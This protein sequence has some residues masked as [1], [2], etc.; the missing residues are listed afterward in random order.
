MAL[1]TAVGCVAAVCA[2]LSISVAFGN[3]ILQSA[4]FSMSDPLDN[5]LFSAGIGFAVL[6]FLLGLLGLVAGLTRVNVIILLIVM[7]AVAGRAWN[8]LPRLGKESWLN[9]L[10]GLD[11]YGTKLL[12]ICIGFFLLLEAILS[13]APLSGSD[14]MQYHFTVPLLHLGTPDRPIFWL[15]NSFLTGLGHELIE[16][17]LALGS[18]RISLMLIFLGGCGTAVALFQLARRW[19]PANWALAAMLTFVATPLVFWQITTAGTPDI[20]MAFYILLAVMAAGQTDVRKNDRWLVL[21]SFYSGAAAG[22]KYTGW[23]IPFVVI[24][25]VLWLS[26]SIWWTALCSLAALASGALPQLRN[27]AWTGDPFFPFL[28]RWIGRVATNPYGLQ[29][30]HDTLGT[31]TISRDPLHL[32]WYS[33]AM[34]LQGSNPSLGNYFGPV[35]LSFIPLLLFC[36]WRTRGVWISGVLWFSMFL[37][38]ALTSQQSRYLLPAYPLALALV[39]S[40]AAVAFANGPRAM[41]YGCTVTLVVFGLFSLALDAGYSKD[42]LPVALGL[43]SKEAF[44]DRMAPDH[45][46]AKFVNTA[47]EYREEKAMVFFR[48]LYYIRVPYMNGDPATSWAVSPDRLTSPQMLLEFLH[49]QDVRWVVKA[50]GYPPAMTAVFEEC[51]RQGSL[52]PEMGT[53][54]ENLSGISRVFSSRIK[55]PVVLMRVVN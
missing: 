50:P 5:I 53:E 18:D 19:M 27:L 24:L 4:E 47:L 13:S 25:C 23:I 54:I 48:H 37:S 36:K 29:S 6:Q 46:A 15:M 12:A 42:F 34:V 52:V 32:L 51:E 20:W 31:A 11:S 45:Q 35:V 1:I 44:L 38:V 8:M 16:L 43:E 2:I 55:V 7:A 3:R 28:G 17:G 49:K 41:R 21:A 33:V 14:A 10:A 22:M 9:A 39:F 40:C 30:L 26:R